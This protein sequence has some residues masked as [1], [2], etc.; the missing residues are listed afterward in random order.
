MV[1]MSI[2]DKFNQ[3]VNR[4]PYLPDVIEITEPIAKALTGEQVKVICDAGKEALRDQQERICNDLA[5]MRQ[6]D[7][8]A[9]IEAHKTQPETPTV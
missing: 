3:L 4:A 8:T 6:K 1:K 2:E 9:W 7:R 5:K